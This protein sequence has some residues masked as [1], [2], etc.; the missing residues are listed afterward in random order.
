MSETQ[1]TWYYLQ[2]RLPRGYISA[3]LLILCSNWHWIYTGN[4]LPSL[5]FATFSVFHLKVH[6]QL[7]LGKLQMKQAGSETKLKSICVFGKNHCLNWMLLSVRV[8]WFVCLCGGIPSRC[9]LLQHLSR[10]DTTR[11]F[12]CDF[13]L[14]DVRIVTSA[15]GL[16]RSFW[17][18]AASFLLGLKELVFLVFCFTR[19][20]SCVHS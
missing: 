15:L 20:R 9:L 16:S 7:P 3:M 12:S 8:T 13:P 19:L 14:L 6:S 1:L 18:V 2:P 5:I 4:M 10:H 11:C 17:S